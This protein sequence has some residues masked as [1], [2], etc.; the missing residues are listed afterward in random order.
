MQSTDS[1][2]SLQVRPNGRTIADEYLHQN[3]TWIEGR[4]LSRY[5]VIIGNKSSSKALFIVAIDGL[6][7][8]EGKPAGTQSQGYVVNPYSSVTIP[9]WKLNN[10][11]AAEFFFSRK[12]ESYVNAIGGNTANTG[13]IGAMVF[14]EKPSID[15]N[16]YRQFVQLG[17][18]THGYNPYGTRSGTSPVLPWYGIN[19]NHVDDGN[20]KSNVTNSGMNSS[21]GSMSAQIP[22]GVYNAASPV[23]QDVATGF[24]NATGFNTSQVSFVREDENNPT[25]ILVMY[26][27]TA[28]NLQKMGIQLRTRHNSSYSPNPFPATASSGC[29]PPKI[30]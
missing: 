5:E 14:R 16:I 19:S 29:V 20:V 28:K 9:G 21:V 27:N 6:D 3:T 25:A 7:V 8:I 23:T 11:E 10:Q 17:Q 18:W 2:Y 1:L 4:E 15:Y 30:W 24:G 22:I 12:S 13:V 26:Y